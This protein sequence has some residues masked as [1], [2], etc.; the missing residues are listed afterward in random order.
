[1]AILRSWS[2]CYDPSRF[3]AEDW[4]G[5]VLDILKDDRIPHEDRLWVALRTELVTERTMRL[6]AVWSARQ[7]QH[8]M[9]NPRSIEAI[10]VAERFANG[11]ATEQE[12]AA[13]WDA[14]RDAAL[15]AAWAAARD[16]ELDAARAAWAAAA[17]AAWA[18]AWAA[19]TDVARAAA[20]DA[21]G[22]AR[23]AA[24]A[25]V[26]DAA[27]AAGRNAARDAALDAQINK[28]IEMLKA[29]G[30]ERINK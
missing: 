18:A 26:R 30:K 15:A 5:T 22:V 3:F 13:A 23:A 2:P 1:M 11:E 8:L 19:A 7:I 10:D 29:E 16:A 14:A 6:F 12:L 27:W 21:T 4:T 9:K 24:W 17:R 20:Y 25:A 28:L